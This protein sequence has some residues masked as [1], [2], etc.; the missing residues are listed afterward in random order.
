MQPVTYQQLLAQHYEESARDLLVYQEHDETDIATN[1]SLNPVGTIL[2]DP[3]K[4][5]QFGGDRAAGTHIIV[6]T[7]FKDKGK[8]SVRYNKDVQTNI[9]CIDTRFRS[10]ADPGISAGPASLVGISNFNTRV[11]NVFSTSTAYTSNFIFHIERLIRNTISSKITSI[12]LPNKFYNLVDIRY[13]N[14]IQ[15]ALG[16]CSSSSNYVQVPVYMT[17]MFT[18]STSTCL[19]KTSG[20]QLGQ[21]GFYYS[22]TTIIPALN[23]A[24]SKAIFPPARIASG[25]LAIQK[26]GGNIKIYV[27]TTLGLSESS[28]SNP[29]Y[30]T[31]NSA[32]TNFN[33]SGTYIITS[34]GSDTTGPYC[35]VNYSFPGNTYYPQPNA[36]GTVSTPTKPK[37]FSDV[38]VSYVNGY[39]QFNNS[40]TTQTYTL[41]FLPLSTDPK[42]HIYTPLGNMLGFNLPTYDIL[43]PSISTT[44]TCGFDCGQISSC[45]SYGSVISEDPID[46]NADSYVYLAIADWNN[47]QH[48]SVNDTSFKAFSRIPITVPKGHLIYD[49]LFNSSITKIYHFTQP[50]NIQQFQVTLLDKTGNILLM[51]NVEWSMII[52]LEEVLS[53]A[54]YEKLREL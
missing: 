7:P 48:E 40:S 27:D 26:I 52:E 46:M 42:P 53:Q 23:T 1:D 24:I 35:I 49:T 21:T 36:V 54:L 25:D 5:T 17:D 6:P 14:Y 44:S 47:V 16:S 34:V 11:N 8:T 15:I 10:Y 28:T 30:V 19:P 12:E 33:T 9:F 22:N 18:T 20:G 41:N 31:I 39:C 2:V 45:E 32:D 29:Y 4:F 50:T 13:N 43:P 51:P 3:Q 37:Y 38:S